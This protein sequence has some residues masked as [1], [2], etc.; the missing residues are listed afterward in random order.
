MKQGGRG[1]K[2]RGRG[3]DRE[4]KGGPDEWNKV[5]R[6]REKRER[7]RERDKPKADGSRIGGLRIRGE[8]SKVDIN[9]LTKRGEK[10]KKVR[11]VLC[12]FI[13]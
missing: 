12:M 6:E 13:C 7:E 1:D 3:R 9:W 11:A 4:G 5:E 10:S 8:K 2:K